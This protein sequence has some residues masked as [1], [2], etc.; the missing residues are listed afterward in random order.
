MNR[1]AYQYTS[2]EDKLFLYSDV[3]IQ[4]GEEIYII[5]RNNPR[6]KFLKL[7]ISKIC[8]HSIQMKM[9]CCTLLTIFEKK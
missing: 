4:K 5:P 7:C 1:R 9:F 2:T 3:I 6:Y 8:D